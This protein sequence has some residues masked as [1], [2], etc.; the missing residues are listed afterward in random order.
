[1]G[2]RIPHSQWALLPLVKATS[3]APHR[4]KWDGPIF[5]NFLATWREVVNAAPYN[6]GEVVFVPD[7]NGYKRAII[8]SVGV[9]RNMYGDLVETYDVSAECK[10]GYFSRLYYAV[11][12][13]QI[14]RAYRR[15]GLAPEI[16]EGEIK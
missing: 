6:R 7:G 14:Q 3:V 4:Y 8:L 11:H 10:D 1:M 15:A 16:P 12:P 13:G 5:D 2:R 9:R